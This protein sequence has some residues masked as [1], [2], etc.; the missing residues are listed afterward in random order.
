M[1]KFV[2][3]KRSSLFYSTAGDEIKKFYNIDPRLKKI[4]LE[5]IC[6][7]VSILWSIELARV[8]EHFKI[9]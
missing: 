6:A 2:M 9:S 7:G 4:A 3:G 8:Q 5:L 1:K